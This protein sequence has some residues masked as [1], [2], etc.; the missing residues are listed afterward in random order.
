MLRSSLL[1]VTIGVVATLDCGGRETGSILSGSANGTRSGT[2]GGGPYCRNGTCE[3]APEP[4]DAS[5]GAP[6]DASVAVDASSA[7]QT[8]N[9]GTGATDCCPSDAASGGACA[10][11]I[12]CWTQCTFGTSD[13]GQGWRGSMSCTS[14]RWI[15][16]HG[17]FP[18]YRSDAGAVSVNDAAADAGPRVACPPVEP[19]PASPCDGPIDCRYPGSCGTVT[20][21]CGVSKS[22]WAVSQ[23]PMCSGAC[24]ASEPRQGDPCMAPGKCS[25]TSACGSQ[26]IVFCDGTGT[27]MR[28]DV[29]ACPACPAQEPAPLTP[30]SG[31]LSCPYTNACSGTDVANCMSSEWTVLRG[32]CE[33]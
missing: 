8:C 17:L 11:G 20:W 14:G 33:K 15:A 27:V 30:C 23:R 31:P 1:I 3:L 28:I 16:G 18:C 25:Y 2:S 26:D 5:V 10:P 6:P 21:T 4:L 19:T 29:G 32:D 12:T 24:P 9:D 7:T 13:T 22:Y